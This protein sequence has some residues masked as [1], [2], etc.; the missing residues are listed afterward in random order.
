MKL[1]DILFKFVFDITKYMED[2]E[3]SKSEWQALRD[4]AYKD[5]EERIEKL[6][7]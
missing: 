7:A 5:A 1:E 6:Y 3:L 2:K 4:R